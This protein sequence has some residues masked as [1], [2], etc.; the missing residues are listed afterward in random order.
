[1]PLLLQRALLLL[2]QSSQELVLQAGLRD[3]KVNEGNLG[4]ELRGVLDIWQP[5]GEHDLEGV[6]VVHLLVRQHN[7]HG[8]ARLDKLLLQD[9]VQYRVKLVLDI[10]NQQGLAK[11]QALLKVQPEALVR[12]RRDLQLVLDVPVGQ[13]GLSLALW[14]DE[15]GVSGG[16]GDDERV[17]DA[18]VVHREALE[19]PLSDLRLISEEIGDGHRLGDGNL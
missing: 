5:C 10:L 9:W 12:Q 3:S 1:M 14:V 6:R 19:V 11:A 13:P 8:L 16:P 17:L 15:Q 7:L 18:Q 2:H 4:G